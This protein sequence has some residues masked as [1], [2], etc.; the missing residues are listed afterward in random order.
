MNTDRE[1]TETIEYVETVEPE[2][3]PARILEW[4]GYEDDPNEPF[5]RPDDPLKNDY[6]RSIN[7]MYARQT[8]YIE[9]KKDD[10]FW[11]EWHKI[12]EYK[13]EHPEFSVYNVRQTPPYVEYKGEKVSCIAFDY[14]IH[15][16]NR[17]TMKEVFFAE[18]RPH[19][20]DLTDGFKKSRIP[21]LGAYK[22]DKNS[23][24]PLSIVYLNDEN[25]NQFTEKQLNFWETSCR[26]RGLN[27]NNILLAIKAEIV[28]Y[29]LEFVKDEG[30]TQ[31][32][33]I[34]EKEAVEFLK[35]HA[36]DLD[37]DPAGFR[38]FFKNNFTEFYEAGTDR[39]IEGTVT[40]Y[41]PY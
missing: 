40:E 8:G 23:N 31:C 37:T 34:S 14:N 7:R 32:R 13:K 26:K 30:T 25:H 22:V 20:F 5:I 12:L 41:A 16:Y 6:F 28:S 27:M 39:R 15:F 33:D 35:R 18:Y 29:S 2:T 36:E 10:R 17:S 4:I 11:K 3:A 19:G 1:N 24:Q 9:V 21:I 38:I